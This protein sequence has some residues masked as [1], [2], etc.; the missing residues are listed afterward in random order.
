MTT[1]AE[2]PLMSTYLIAFVVSDFTCTEGAEIEANI[3]YSVCSRSETYYTRNH[4]VELGPKIIWALEELT[5]VKYSVSGIG[6]MDQ[7]AIP[8]FAAGAME[9]WG[10]VTY[11]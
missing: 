10:L 8:D 1:F 3:P 11:R 4:A 5:G 2:T 6:K 9:N 7:Y